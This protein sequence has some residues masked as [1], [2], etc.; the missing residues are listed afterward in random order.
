MSIEACKTK[1]KAT[2]S[3]DLKKLYEKEQ[4]ILDEATF[5][6]NAKTVDDISGEIENL[7]K[8]FPDPKKFRTESLKLL[9]SMRQDKL[10]ARIE[11]VQNKQTVNKLFAGIDDPAFLDK[12]GKINFVEAVYQP[13]VGTNLGTKGANYNVGNV[14]ESNHNRYMN[15]LNEIFDKHEL[16][17]LSKGLGDGLP[18]DVQ[19]S[20]GEIVEIGFTKSRGKYP[21][22]LIAIAQKVKKFN[23]YM[24]KESIRA[25]FDLGYESNY[26]MRSYDADKLIKNKKGAIEQLKDSIDI[27]ESFPNLSPK[28]IDE[29]LDGVVESIIKGDLTKGMMDMDALERSGRSSLEARVTK[30]RKFKFKPGKTAQ[31]N[32]NFGKGTL[33]ENLISNAKTMSKQNALREVLG[34]NPKGNHEKFVQKLIKK[35]DEMGDTDAVEALR[36][37]Q[38]DKSSKE[39]P[40]VKELVG[41]LK[42]TPT[43]KAIWS[44][45]DG[46]ATRPGNKTIA[47]LA[48]NFRSLQYMAILGKSMA[49]A[50]TDVANMANML[51]AQTGKS[52]LG[53]WGEVLKGSLESYPGFAKAYATGDVSPQMRST[54]KSLNIHIETGMGAI[55]RHVGVDGHASK[56]MA[57]MTDFFTRINPIG[58]QAAFHKATLLSAVGDHLGKVIRGGEIDGSITRMLDRAGFTEDY[59]PVLKELVIDVDDS[60][61]AFGSDAIED[62]SIEVLEATKRKLGQ[63]DAK[64]LGMSNTKFKDEISRK[65]DVMFIDISNN[66]VPTPGLKQQSAMNQG[67]PPGTAGGELL[68]TV[69]M[70]KS[71][72]LKMNDSIGSIYHARGGGVEGAAAISAYM[73]TLTGMGY[74]AMS[75]KDM[76]NNQTP[77]DITDPKT[78]ADAF[79]QGGSAGLYGDFATQFLTND[80]GSFAS[81]MSGPMISSIEKTSRLFTKA[82]HG[83]LKRKDINTMIGLTPFNNHLVLRPMM[84]YMF[85]EDMMNANDPKRARRLRKKMRENG[86]KRLIK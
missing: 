61:M 16:K 26:L 86:Q 18:D 23:D 2:L 72:A 38:T 21:E 13:L 54:L 7:A 32:A 50:V 76:L 78:W 37:M 55:F 36:K 22:E 45:L 81:S 6:F 34:P 64:Y 43:T 65:I 44:N 1:A 4:E 24:Y 9:N 10:K 12:K 35:A 11:T 74:A 14:I 68:R 27:D 17:I 63:S 46:T 62:I 59:L 84:N 56:G 80:N 71:F 53:S 58:L 30:G 57:A 51:S 39:K 47:W 52:Y 31:W 5:L 67:L 40:T 79:M 15:A 66:G 82:I 19:I 42:M 69:G 75:I 29:V 85:L 25:G 41:A 49:T 20:I 70:L 3:D 8:R 77:R 33:M 60:V 83:D 48:G 73:V 28:Q